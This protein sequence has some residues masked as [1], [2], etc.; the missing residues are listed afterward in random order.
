ML[1]RI[2]KTWDDLLSSSYNVKLHDVWKKNQ[3]KKD[4]GFTWTLYVPHGHC[5]QFMDTKNVQGHENK[6][7]Y[8]RFGD[9]KTFGT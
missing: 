6:M 8:V 1:Q 2:P 5:H 7:P 9:P 4:V 3:T